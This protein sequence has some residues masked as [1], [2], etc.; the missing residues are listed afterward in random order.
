MLAGNTAVPF[1]LNFPPGALLDI[2][3]LQYPLPAESRQ[4]GFDLAGKTGISPRPAGV[5]DED[6]FVGF[7]SSV[8]RLDGG[9]GNF[10]K[11][12]AKILV[13]LASDVNLSRIGQAG[14][15]V[16]WN[17]VFC[18]THIAFRWMGV[19]K[20]TG[21]SR[22]RAQNFIAVPPQGERPKAIGKQSGKRLRRC[23]AQEFGRRLLTP[24]FSRTTHKPKQKTRTEE[25]TASRIHKDRPDEAASGF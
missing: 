6:G 18:S 15:A 3:A 10:P 12:N 8:Q 11:R 4:S 17:Y 5:I 22:T 21:V 19:G 14:G 7:Q 9:L 25:Y 13:P 2:P 24:L 1:C 20:R 16:R 23:Q